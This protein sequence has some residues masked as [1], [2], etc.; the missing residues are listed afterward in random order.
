MPLFDLYLIETTSTIIE[1]KRLEWVPSTQTTSSLQKAASYSLFFIKSTKNL[2]YQSF[3]R[4]SI[5][6]NISANFTNA[7]INNSGPDYDLFV[8]LPL[9]KSFKVKGRLNSISKIQITPS[10]D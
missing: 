7:E 8:P 3:T 6:N 4:A 5:D 9:K 2:P 10:L 1:R